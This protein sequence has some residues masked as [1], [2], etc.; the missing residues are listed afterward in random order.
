MTCLHVYLNY[1]RSVCA[2]IQFAQTRMWSYKMQQQ[3]GRAERER[4]ATSAHTYRRMPDSPR[5]RRDQ[6][7]I[8]FSSF[9]LQK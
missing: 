2:V 5:N 1:F 3:G 7:L 6:A 8:L 9:H 4:K